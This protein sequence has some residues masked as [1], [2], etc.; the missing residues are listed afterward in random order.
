MNSRLDIIREKLL[1]K[2]TEHQNAGGQ[3]RNQIMAK[4]FGGRRG[5]KYYL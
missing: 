4:R 3:V 5:T 2:I 1:L